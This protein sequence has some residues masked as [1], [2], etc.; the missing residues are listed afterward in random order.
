MQSFLALSRSKPGAVTYRTF[1]L[2]RHTKVTIHTAGVIEFT[3][4]RDLDRFTSATPGAKSLLYSCGVHGNETAP[5]EI[6]DALVE[7]IL[8]ETIQVQHRLMVQFANLPAMDI[9][10]R[11]VDENMNRLFSGAHQRSE[12]KS[13]E[14]PRAAELEVYTKDF[15]ERGPA[16]FSRY[17]Y[18]LHTAI[19]DSQHTRFAVYPYLHG[20]PY[21]Q[22]QMLWLADAG[23]TA[24]LLSSGPTTT[25]SYYS[26]NSCGA[27][28][29]TV[30][31]GKVKPFGQNN[32]DD[33]EQARLWLFALV[34][35]V[36]YKAK[37]DTVP[38]LFQI[39]QSITRQETDFKLHFADDT[40]N[41]TAFD[42]DTVL[43][44][45]YDKTG[46]CI[47]EY[48]ATEDGEAIVFPNAHVA[49]GQRA[50]LTVTPLMLSEIPVKEV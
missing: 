38:T 5:I 49:L 25:Y 34:S 33:F 14:A 47:N 50:L 11:F 3:P 2:G 35:Q 15:F 17:H 16:H 23:V 7:A 13:V 30:E 20:Q 36:H 41:F 45:E 28:A 24:L 39:H 21:D 32:M 46:Q 26:A 43:A 42:K 37:S 44:S 27:H 9:A 10:Q 48:R 29:F 6:C 12:L 31:L 8:S 18:D 40:P 22:E 4:L 19:R 1:V